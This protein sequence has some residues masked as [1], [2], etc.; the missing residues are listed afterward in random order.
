VH[1]D[2]DGLILPPSVAPYQV[3][4]IPITREDTATALNE[5]AE[6][7]GDKLRCA[8]VRV[9][10]DTTDMRAPDKMWKWIKRGVPLRV[11]IGAREMESESITI[12]RRDLGR[13]SKRTITV[14]ELVASVNDI[15]RDIHDTM[16]ARVEKRNAEMIHDV[17]DLTALDAALANGVI[18][19]FRIKYEKTTNEQFDGL[20]EKYKI[21]R[22][23]LDDRDPE[24]V[25]VAKSY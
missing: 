20:M 24:Y 10:V 25:F 8:E 1:S 17:A 13:E 6:N 5:Y 16:V 7:L 11:E 4:I 23:C 21:T 14:D 2:D 15:M 3:V 18:G 9:L 22:R 12:T 19:F